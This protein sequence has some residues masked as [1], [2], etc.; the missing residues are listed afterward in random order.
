MSRAADFGRPRGTDGYAPSNTRLCLKSPRRPGWLGL[1]EGLPQWSVVRFANH[2]HPKPVSKQSLARSASAGKRY[3]AAYPRLGFGLMF[4]PRHPMFHALSR[5]DLLS[6]TAA[7]SAT[8][9]F[10]S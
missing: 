5:R 10:A 8:A 1:P 9:L 4:T 7:A 3:Y 2:R 6:A